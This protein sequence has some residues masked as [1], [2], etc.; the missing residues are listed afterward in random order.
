METKHLQVFKLQGRRNRMEFIDGFPGVASA[1]KVKD[2]IYDGVARPHNGDNLEERQAIWDQR[3]LLALEKLRYY[4]S[5]KVHLVVAK[6]NRELTAREYYQALDFM[7][8]RTTAESTT[9]LEEKLANCKLR[10]HDELFEWM[11]HLDAIYAG[12]RAAGEP[13]SDAQMKLRAMQKVGKEWAS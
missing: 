10:I 7:F 9:V 5:D 2:L 8:L 1:F 12:F 6:G 3:N 13:K 4:V 11:A